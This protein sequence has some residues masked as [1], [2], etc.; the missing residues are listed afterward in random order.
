MIT[1]IIINTFIYFLKI[2]IDKNNFKI[3]DL[4]NFKQEEINDWWVNFTATFAIAEVEEIWFFTENIIRIKI[5]NYKNYYFWFYKEEKEKIEKETEILK[6]S[7]NIF[8]IPESNY[9]NKNF[10]QKYINDIKV[11]DKI[12]FENIKWIENKE[13]YLS[14]E[15]FSNLELTKIPEIWDEKYIN[16]KFFVSYTCKNEKFI[17]NKKFLKEEFLWNFIWN[18]LI[19]EK[20][21]FKKVFQKIIEKYKICN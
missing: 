15:I 21:K 12:I 7:K 2:E 8:L 9:T 19:F 20:H 1:N 17:L 10:F 6:N 14:N 4:Q 16:T 18:N 5:K 3:I 13:K 11:W